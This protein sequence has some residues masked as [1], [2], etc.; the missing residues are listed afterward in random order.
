MI[1]YSLPPHQF[2]FGFVSQILSFRHSS[3]T[4]ESPLEQRPTAYTP[5]ASMN[6]V[7]ARFVVAAAKRIKRRSYEG[8]FLA[9]VPPSAPSPAFVMEHDAKQKRGETTWGKLRCLEYVELEK[10]IFISHH[11]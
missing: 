2:F 9:R 3:L 7:Q 11:V 6:K 5:V 4:F 1:L 10:L 8:G